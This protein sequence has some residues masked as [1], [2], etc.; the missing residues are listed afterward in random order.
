MR[1]GRSYHVLRE[2]NGTSSGVNSELEYR[3]KPVDWEELPDCNPNDYVLLD[4]LFN[5]KGLPVASIEQQKGKR[6]LFICRAIEANAAV[7]FPTYLEGKQWCEAVSKC[8]V[9]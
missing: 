7:I 1:R 6:V 8:Q 2:R 3:W 9:N 4:I 5:D